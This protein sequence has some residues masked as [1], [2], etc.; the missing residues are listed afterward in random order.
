MLV[1]AFKVMSF[2]RYGTI[3]TFS[4]FKLYSHVTI[5]LQLQLSFD[6]YDGTLNVHVLQ[7]KNLQAKDKNGFSDPYVK[8]YLLP[9]KK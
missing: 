6:D 3:S 2:R 8:V 4:Y 7:A 9:G 1:F 5:C